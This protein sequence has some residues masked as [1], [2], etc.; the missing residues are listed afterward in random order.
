MK[1]NLNNAMSFQLIIYIFKSISDM[2]MK[3]ILI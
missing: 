1:V 3:N 2:T